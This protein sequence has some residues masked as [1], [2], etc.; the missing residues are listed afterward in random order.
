[1]ILKLLKNTK[2]VSTVVIAIASVIAAF[3]LRGA[4]RKPDVVQENI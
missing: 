4:F 1:M 2:V 3:A